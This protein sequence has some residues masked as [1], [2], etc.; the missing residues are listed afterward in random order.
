MAVE[1]GQR[2]SLNRTVFLHHLYLRP[3]EQVRHTDSLTKLQ[4]LLG[5]GRPLFHA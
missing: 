5:T 1:H 2:P 4:N 3:G